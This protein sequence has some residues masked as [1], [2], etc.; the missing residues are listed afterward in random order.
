[1]DQGETPS[2]LPV[3]PGAAT[4]VTIATV[5]EEWEDQLSTETDK[6]A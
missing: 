5:V 2:Y 1:V 6:A 3:T 4:P